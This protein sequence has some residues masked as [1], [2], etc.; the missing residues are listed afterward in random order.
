MLIAL[1]VVRTS[2]QVPDLVNSSLPSPLPGVVLKSPWRNSS[3]AS[4]EE[5]YYSFYDN[6]GL[7]NKLTRAPLLGLAKFIYYWIGN[8][9]SIRSATHLN[10]P[11]TCTSIAR[12]QTSELEAINSQVNIPLA[13]SSAVVTGEINREALCGVKLPLNRSLNW[14]LTS[15]V[16]PFW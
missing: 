16:C 1:Q 2:S 5:F 14:S 10:S 13:L 7:E 6:E 12:T 15:P 4:A 11:I 3:T 8:I 9:I